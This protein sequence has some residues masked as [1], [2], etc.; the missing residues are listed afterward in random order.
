MIRTALLSFIASLLV[1]SAVYAADTLHLDPVKS[2]GKHVVLISG[3]EEY[4][5]EESMPMLAKILSQKHGFEC[6]VVFS[7]GPN[8]A[9]YIDANNQQGL[10][11]LE[12]GSAGAMI[13]F[14]SSLW[15]IAMCMTKQAL[16]I[17][18]SNSKH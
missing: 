11:G 17:S 1:V 10:R 6:T 8:G 15:S 18:S 12:A 7:F 9:G 4:R 2:N 3:D 13:H 5:S 14:S 16:A